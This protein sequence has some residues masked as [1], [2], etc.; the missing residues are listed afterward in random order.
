M[1]GCLPHP[2]LP[3]PAVTWGRTLDNAKMLGSFSD[4]PHPGGLD[5]T[6]EN[7]ELSC[8]DGFTPR[9]LQGQI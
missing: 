4:C 5:S 9:L 3:G 1:A 7:V 2:C 6:H 8:E